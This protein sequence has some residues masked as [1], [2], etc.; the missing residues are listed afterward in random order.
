MYTSIPLC[1]SIMQQPVVIFHK[2][3]LIVNR[4]DMSLKTY[5]LINQNQTMEHILSF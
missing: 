2:H 1:E 4:N 3:H 5:P